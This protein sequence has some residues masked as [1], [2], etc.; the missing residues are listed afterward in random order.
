[1]TILFLVCNRAQGNAPGPQE[2]SKFLNR[3][4]WFLANGWYDAAHS[5]VDKNI[6]RALRNGVGTYTF[7]PG[8]RD[9]RLTPEQTNRDTHF[10]KYLQWYCVA[11]RTNAHKDGLAAAP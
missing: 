9:Y 2:F 7:S 4:F 11:G 6:R 1:M 3:E 5:R 10:E 8:T